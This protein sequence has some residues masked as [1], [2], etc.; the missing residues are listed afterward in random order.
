MS[1]KLSLL[2]KW[3]FLEMFILEMAVGWFGATLAFMCDN[4]KD[5]GLEDH[6]FYFI[7]GMVGRWAIY[8]PG[9]K[10]NGCF[11][12]IKFP[13]NLFFVDDAWLILYYMDRLFYQILLCKRKNI[14]LMFDTVLYIG[15]QCLHNI[16]QNISFIDKI[17]FMQ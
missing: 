2:A 7:V 17:R 3:N 9:F 13:G 14:C 10:K 1:K 6:M 8:V 4:L 16:F 11:D 5:K 12:K 15:E